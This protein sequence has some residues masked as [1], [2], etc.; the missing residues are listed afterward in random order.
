MRL[1]IY[2]DELG[3][4]LEGV[5]VPARGR[6]LPGGDPTP[7]EPYVVL[8]S[9]LPADRI[10]PA[11]IHQLAH[12]SLLAFNVGSPR[13][14]SEATAGFLTIAAS[15][16]WKGNEAALRV[17]LGHPERGLDSDDP[18]TMAGGLLWPEFL[19]ERADD[20]AVVRQVW[21]EMA[22]QSID[23]LA[24]ADIVLRRSGRTLPD[25]YREYAA[26]NLFTGERDDGQHYAFG[27]ALPAPALDIAGPDLPFQR[28]LPDAVAPL[29]SGALRIVGDGR[30]GTVDLD[31]RSEGGSPGA[32][33]LVF[34]RSWG[35]QP[36]LVPVSFDVSGAAGVSIPWSDAREAWLVLRHDA[37]SGSAP[38]LFEVRGAEDPYAPYD[39]ASFTALPIGDSL[40]LEWTTASEKGLLVWNVY[41]SETP[42]GPFTR[43][44]SVAVPAAGDTVADTGYLYVDGYVRAGRRYYYLLEGLTRLGLPQ[45]SQVVSGRITPADVSPSPA[46]GW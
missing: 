28:E 9:N 8:D 14:W 39:L 41:R 37:P 13:F 20:P 45:R 18:A 46:R 1:D 16:D 7:Q 27:R 40:Q 38:V 17:R 2:V 32:D 26:W 22:Q 36:V 21:E 33:L 42:N 35:P 10:L 31:I 29:G 23:P 3:H 44:N 5:T 43:L 24:A 11:A 4:G 34:Y 19:A 30:R 12:L 6:G 15:G 25:A